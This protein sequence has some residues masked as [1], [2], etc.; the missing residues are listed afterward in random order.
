MY[1]KIDIYIF[2]E[3]RKEWS[4]ECSTNMA[5]TCKAAKTRYCALYKVDPA[6]VKCRY[7]KA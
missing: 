1:K 3:V 4:Y 2:N 5:K 6:L 7:N